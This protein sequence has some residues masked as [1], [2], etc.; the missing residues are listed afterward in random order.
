M[1]RKIQ[2]VVAG[3]GISGEEQEQTN[4]Q[5]Q[6]EALRGEKEEC[7]KELRT[8]GEMLE[9]KKETDRV[10]KEEMIQEKKQVEEELI[11]E[12]EKYKETDREH[13]EEL[14]QYEALLGDEDRSHE[15]EMIQYEI[16]LREKEKK[17]EELHHEIKEWKRQLGEKCKDLYQEIRE[18]KRQ[19]A[20]KA[21]PEKEIESESGYES[22]GSVI[23][24]INTKRS[25]AEVA[26][27]KGK[28]KGKEKGP[29]TPPSA[30][31]VVTTAPPSR[32]PSPPPTAKAR[33]VV[34]HAAPLH[35]K[36]GTMRRW[37]EEDNKGVEIMGIR[38]LTREHWPG[39]VASSL[40]IYMRSAMEI[41]R[42]RMGRKLFHTTRYDWG[43]VSA[44]RTRWL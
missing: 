11:R 19:R 24:V 44:K 25:Y 16:L 27:R 15:E 6:V 18:L 34:M 4:E 8:L 10:Q 36:P 22:T 21:T 35:Y 1:E 33:A 31:S 32:P 9:W 43:R 29:T 3:L 2:E 40:V 41:G 30:G 23:T 5:K 37:I 42:L 38:W 12:K 17:E 28:G 7:E 20:E 13:Q 14:I 26:K 39:K